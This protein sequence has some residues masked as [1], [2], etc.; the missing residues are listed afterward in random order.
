MHHCIET[1]YNWPGLKT[2]VGEEEIVYHFMDNA[3]KCNSFNDIWSV[4]DGKVS[5][6]HYTATLATW[7]FGLNLV[8]FE[9]TPNGGRSLEI[10]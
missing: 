10:I 1:G 4:T 5:V 6:F 3:D 9:Y 2:I 7:F 8:R